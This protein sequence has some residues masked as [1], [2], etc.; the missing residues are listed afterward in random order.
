MARVTVEDCVEVIPNRFELVALAAQRGKQ[1]ASGAALTLDRDND[2]D[3]VVALREI[4]EQ[5]IE[6]ETIE[7]EVVASY[8][9]YKMSESVAPE[10]ASDEAIAASAVSGDVDEAFKDAQEQ[11]IEAGEDLEQHMSFEGMDEDID[12]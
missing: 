1:I 7:Q 10:E 4:A 8:S 6:L 11:P 5:T 9:T 12:D 3:A 2:K